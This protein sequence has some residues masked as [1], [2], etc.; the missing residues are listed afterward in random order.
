MQKFYEKCGL[1]TSSRLFL[2]FTESYVQ[3]NM[4]RSVSWFGKILIVLLIHIY[5]HIYIQKGLDLVFCRSFWEI[6]WIVFFLNLPQTDQISLT[7]CIYFAS[8][9]VKCISC[10]MVRHLMTPWN[11]N[12]W[13]SKIWFS[14]EWKTLLKWNENHFS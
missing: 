11:L 4:R 1:E 2:I 6:F 8:Y 14:R 7:D 10:F 9:L 12:I 5:M 13:N 3:R